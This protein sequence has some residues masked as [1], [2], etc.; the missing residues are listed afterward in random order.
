MSV[1]PYDTPKH[2]AFPTSRQ[3]AA[4]QAAAAIQERHAEAERRRTKGLEAELANVRA[5][6]EN[7]TRDRD[8]LQALVDGYGEDEPPIVRGALDAQADAEVRMFAERDRAQSLARDMAHL[9]ALHEHTVASLA[10]V[11]SE[12][13]RVVAV[14]G[15]IGHGVSVTQHGDGSQIRRAVSLLQTRSAVL[16]EVLDGILDGMSTRVRALLADPEIGILDARHPLMLH[17]HVAGAVMFK[18]GWHWTTIGEAL[19]QRRLERIAGRNRSGE[20]EAT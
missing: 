4:S 15:E 16:D 10:S 17:L 9:R 2:A 19:R 5:A 1:D 3:D 13:T 7:V 14:L 11:T 20:Y 18:D 8:Q 6:L 12:L